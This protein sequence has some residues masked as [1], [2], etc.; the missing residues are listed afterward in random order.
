MV[1]GLRG[2]RLVGPL[3]AGLLC[4]LSGAGC[5]LAPKSFAQMIHPSGI[6]RARAAGLS[7][8]QPDQVAVPAL[9]ERLGDADPVVR[10]T[11]HETLRERTGQNFGYLPWGDNAERAAAQARWKTWWDQQPQGSAEQDSVRDATGPKPT[12]RGQSTTLASGR[13]GGLGRRRRL[14]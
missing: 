12:V 11:A 14:R 9:I 5:S 4:L 2:M 1:D 7:D 10:L 3:V 8:R 13:K 6:V